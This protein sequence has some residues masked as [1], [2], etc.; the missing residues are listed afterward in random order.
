MHPFVGFINCA[1]PLCVSRHPRS[2]T[3]C[4][5][6]CLVFFPS[7]TSVTVISESASSHR[8]V[9]QKGKHHLSTS[10]QP[11]QGKRNT[12]L[13]SISCCCSKQIPASNPQM[14][15][16]IFPFKVRQQR[17][18]TL[19]RLEVNG[20]KSLKSF[21]RWQLYEC[22]TNNAW[23]NVS[24]G[25]ITQLRCRKQILQTF[26]GIVCTKIL[27]LS[28]FSH[29]RVVPKRYGLFRGTQN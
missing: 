26:K 4:C 21:F 7:F 25:I 17:N 11:T 20:E 13:P 15:S 24:E 19:R 16:F 12:A 23:N 22:N 14:Q 5:W 3:C 1:S 18:A 6:Q 27:I 2:R 28:S 8:L 9:R 10:A 29:H